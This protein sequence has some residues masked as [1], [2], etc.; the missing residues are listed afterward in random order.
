M[1]IKSVIIDYIHSI[2]WVSLKVFLVCPAEIE[3]RLIHPCVLYAVK[4]GR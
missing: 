1:Q 4:Y 3:V 2:N